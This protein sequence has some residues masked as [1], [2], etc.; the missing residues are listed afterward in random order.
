LEGV[1]AKR[2]VG[3]LQREEGQARRAGGQ[4]QREEVLAQR[5]AGALPQRAKVVG[6]PALLDMC[7]SGTS[8]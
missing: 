8:V 4:Q 7:M 3:M 1:L 2:V 6:R 5:G